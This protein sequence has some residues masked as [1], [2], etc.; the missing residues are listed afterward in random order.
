MGGH[1][2]EWNF[3]ESISQSIIVYGSMSNQLSTIQ[4]HNIYFIYQCI[5]LKKKIL[6]VADLSRFIYGDGCTRQKKSFH[7][8]KFSC[9]FSFFFSLWNINKTSVAGRRKHSPNYVHENYYSS[10]FT[11][12]IVIYPPTFIH[13]SA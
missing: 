2:E 11:P 4:L 8:D 12:K 6:M 5:S 7:Q 3:T 1:S 13:L 10:M 9:L